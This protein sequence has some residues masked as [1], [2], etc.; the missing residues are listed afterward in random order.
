MNKFII[1]M[2][3]L[4]AVVAEAKGVHVR[5]H[6]RSNGTYV[7]PHTRSAPNHSRFDNYSSQGNVN[8]YNGRVGHTNPLAPRQRQANPL[9]R[10]RR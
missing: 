9:P 1:L 6:F 10:R 2:V 7:A 4:F 3:C 5:G 8:P